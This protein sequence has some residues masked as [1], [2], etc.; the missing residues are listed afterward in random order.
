MPVA[1]NQIDELFGIIVKYVPVDRYAD[2]IA[3]LKNTQAYRV[4]KSF[5]VTIDR[6][7]KENV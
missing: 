7:G 4:N 3:D 6:L 2:L 1:K 5:A